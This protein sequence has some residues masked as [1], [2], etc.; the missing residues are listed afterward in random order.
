MLEALEHLH[1]AGVRM[2]I[3]TN[4]PERPTRELLREQGSA[5]RPGI[6]GSRCRRF[7]L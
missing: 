5:L 1:S 3:C 2:G 4:K 7:H 6:P